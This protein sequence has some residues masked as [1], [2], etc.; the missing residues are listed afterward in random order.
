MSSI[1][2]PVLSENDPTAQGTV[3]TWFAPDGAQVAV[4]ELI[5]EVAVDKVDMEITAPA[6]GI[7]THKV[8]EGA[9]VEQHTEIATIG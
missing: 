5:A 8:G 7:L 3:V 9:I 1:R 2:F 6:A 4:G